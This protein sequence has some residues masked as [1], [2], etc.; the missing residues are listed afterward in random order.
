[1]AGPNQDSID[2]TMATKCLELTQ[3]LI[4]MKASCKFSLHLS[5]GFNYSFSNLEHG[6]TNTRKIEKKKKSPY[7]LRRNAKRREEY[8][9]KKMDSSSQPTPKE[10]EKGQ[11]LSCTI[12]DYVG[13]SQSGLNVHMNRMHKIIP[14]LDGAE[15]EK[16]CESPNYR[17]LQKTTGYRIF[18]CLCDQCGQKIWGLNKLKEYMKASHNEVKHRCE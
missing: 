5:N 15:L 18:H 1:M 17:I 3:T 12:C 6:N 10:Q 7:T 11:T 9:K 8:I 16:V 14:Q 4:S 2:V 13:E